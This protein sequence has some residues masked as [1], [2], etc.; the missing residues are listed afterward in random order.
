MKSRQVVF[1]PQFFKNITDSFRYLSLAWDVQWD[2]MACKDQKKH[3]YLPTSSDYVMS[4]II[5]EKD[6]TEMTGELWFSPLKK[7]SR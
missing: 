3:I 2:G 6:L 7:Q 4:E 5:L 1:E